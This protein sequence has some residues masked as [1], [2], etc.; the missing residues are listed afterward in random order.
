MKKTFSQLV[1]EI[2]IIPGNSFVLGRPFFR[3]HPMF[4][5]YVSTQPCIVEIELLSVAVICSTV[6]KLTLFNSGLAPR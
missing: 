5:V 6:T 3:L 1:A 2:T 4:C